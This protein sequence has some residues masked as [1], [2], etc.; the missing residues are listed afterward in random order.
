ML[1]GEG[2]DWTGARAQGN[3]EAQI[4]L[5]LMYHHGYSCPCHPLGIPA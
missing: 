1:S 3:V 2:A 4:M 5:A